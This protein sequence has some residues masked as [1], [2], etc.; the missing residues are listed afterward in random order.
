MPNLCGGGGLF[1]YSYLN[2]TYIEILK[3]LN[4]LDT[5][6]FVLSKVCPSWVCPWTPN[7]TS[8]PNLVVYALASI[9]DIWVN[10]R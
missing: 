6:A 9:P 10:Y 1:V 2:L 3:Y 8:S 5:P 7:P 4:I